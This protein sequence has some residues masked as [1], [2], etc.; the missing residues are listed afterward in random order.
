MTK[1]HKKYSKKGQLSLIKIKKY[2]K[3]MPKSEKKILIND[4][5]SDP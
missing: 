4:T 5:K 3:N 1:N 2:V